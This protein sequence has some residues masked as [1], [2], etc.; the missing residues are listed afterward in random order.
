MAAG[1]GV[2]HS[3][4]TAFVEGKVRD[5]DGDLVDDEQ[6]LRGFRRMKASQESNEETED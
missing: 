1:F 6:L 4:V 2:T 3:Q 5:A